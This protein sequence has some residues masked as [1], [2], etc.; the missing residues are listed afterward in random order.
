MIR[1]RRLVQN[2]QHVARHPTAIARGLP[3]TPIP[4]LL[5]NL[6]SSSS[7]SR[8]GASRVALRRAF[9]GYKGR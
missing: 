6:K 1:L 5:N 7:S 2:D 8:G 9:F 4:R 3:Y